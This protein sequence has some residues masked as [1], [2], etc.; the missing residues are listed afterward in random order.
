L[1]NRRLLDDR[2]FQ[3]FAACKRNSHFGALMFLDLDNFKELNDRYGH[4]LGDL[5]LI[6][7]GH[8][9]IGCL[10]AMDTVARFGGDE[11]VVMLSELSADYAESANQASH[12]AEKI[13]AKLGEPYLLIHQ[14]EGGVETKIVYQCTSSIGFVLFSN[15][16]I[17]EEDVMSRADTA[18]YQAKQGGGNRICFLQDRGEAPS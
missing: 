17:S 16:S 1:P 18:M 8:R 12:V 15:Q 11:F 10:R 2:L 4:A 5:L 6:E 3:A 14:P 7:A 9:I 13:R